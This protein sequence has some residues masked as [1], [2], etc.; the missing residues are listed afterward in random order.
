MPRDE[1]NISKENIPTNT[2]LLLKKGVYSY[3]YM[4]SFKKFNEATLP[5]REA[6]FSSLT[7][8]SFTPQVRS[9]TR[10]LKAIYIK[11]LGEYHDLYVKSDVLQ[12]ADVFENF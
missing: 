7:L 10:C 2:D 12:L 5:P 1:F 11:D 4:T 6:F 3:E 8:E 9:C